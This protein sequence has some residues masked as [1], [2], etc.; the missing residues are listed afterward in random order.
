MASAHPIAPV[1]AA[2]APPPGVGSDEASASVKRS[3][4]VYHSIGGLT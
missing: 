3:A 2:A 4:A 1:M